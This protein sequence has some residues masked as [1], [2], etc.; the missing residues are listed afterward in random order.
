MVAWYYEPDWPR[1][2]SLDRLAWRS[3][4]HAEQTST[5]RDAD[6]AVAAFVLL[7]NFLRR[8]AELGRA[9]KRARRP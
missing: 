7:A 9:V 3:P 8:L 2:R 5:R 4:W 1:P 6:I